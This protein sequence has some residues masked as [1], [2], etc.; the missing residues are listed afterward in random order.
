MA[1]RDAKRAAPVPEKRGKVLLA[2]SPKGGV[3]KTCLTRGMSVSAALD[4]LKVRT[5]DVDPQQSM[6]WWHERRDGVQPVIEHSALPLSETTPE[7][8][9]EAIR[10]AAEDVD[11][12]VVDTPPTLDSFAEPAKVLLLR[13]D[14]VLVPTRCTDDDYMSVIPWMQTLRDMR[15]PGSFVINAAKRRVVS[16]REA[17]ILLVEKGKLCPIAIPDLEDIHLVARVGRSP[18]EV[19]GAKGAEEI[20]GVWKFVRMELGI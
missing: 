19:K 2:A 15:I 18:V 14:F 1:K 7:A 4:G 11:L 13:A 8:L 5:L 9:E 10:T 20:R 12:L 3:G 16:F 17:Q 6:T